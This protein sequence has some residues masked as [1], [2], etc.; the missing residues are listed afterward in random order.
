MRKTPPTSTAPASHDTIVALASGIG[1]SDRALVRLSGR[2]VQEIVG[3]L[4]ADRAP[5][6]GIRAAVLRLGDDVT[7]LGM[8]CLVSLWISPR[9]YTGEDAAEILLPGNPVLVGR[10]IGRLRQIPGVREAEPGEFSA[11]AYLNGR[12]SVEQAEGVAALIGART[13]EQLR[14]ARS[15]RSGEAGARYRAWADEAAT[16]LA[17]VEAGIDFTDQEDVVAIG[18]EALASRIGALIGSIENSLG[19]GAGSERSS[20]LARVVL[21]G[22]PNSGKSTLF[23]ALLGRRRAIT[24][25]VAGTTRDAIVEDVDLSRDV[26]CGPRIEL[27]DLAGLDEGGDE[28]DRASQER[29]GEEV[30]GADAVVLCDPSGRFDVE[31]PGDAHRPIVRVRTKADVPIGH[32]TSAS[33]EVCALDGWNLGVLRR[34]IADAATAARGSGAW[35]IPRHRRTL[36]SAAEALARAR[37]SV[38]SG[39]GSGALPNPELVASHLREATDR[40]GELVGRISPDD[41]IGRIFATFCVGK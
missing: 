3:R 20:G 7:E 38:R 14:A 2:H 22:R 10:V 12:M 31:V 39:R 21:A 29:A 24:S 25:H 35:L 11:R 15:L 32:S 40:L 6:E 37:S 27:V 4:C 18:P 34:A 5:T 36:G 28:I 1:R 30:A 13:D 19:S 41:V 8:P 23:N 17:L 16:L 33:V 9:S 26:P